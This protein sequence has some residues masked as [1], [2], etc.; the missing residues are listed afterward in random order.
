MIIFRLFSKKKHNLSKKEVR[1]NIKGKKVFQLKGELKKKDDALTN[2]EKRFKD[3]NGRTQLSEGTKTNSKNKKGASIPQSSKE[4][5]N[6]R[7]KI[8]TLEVT[9]QIP[10]VSRDS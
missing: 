9:S 5:A 1:K 10:V 6:L 8:K 3:S 2:I 4:M 7:E